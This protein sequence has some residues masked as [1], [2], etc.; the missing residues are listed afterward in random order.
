MPWAA[1][2][3]LDTLSCLPAALSAPLQMV[4]QDFRHCSTSPR[5]FHSLAFWPKPSPST[6]RVVAIAWM[7]GF[8][9]L[10]WMLKSTTIPASTRGINCCRAYS[11]HK[12]LGS[13]TG[14]ANSIS[15]A[16]WAS[17]RFS[18]CSTRF[19]R[20]ARSRHHAGESAGARISEWTTSG[21]GKRK[22]MPRPSSRR[23]HPAR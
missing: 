10:S 14:M 5:S 20:T 23:L 6:R 21:L 13:P 22:V 19:H 8:P 9:G 16:S 12:C 17:F 11:F 3:R 2:D 15:L 18:D 4:S 1:R 7:W